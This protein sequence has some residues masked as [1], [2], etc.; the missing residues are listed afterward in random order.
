MTRY[1]PDDAIGDGATR[2]LLA[3]L[4]SPR[5]TVRGIMEATGKRSTSTVHE[6]LKS[7]RRLGLVTW[8]DHKDGTLRANC[9]RIVRRKVSYISFGRSL[10]G[11]PS[12]RFARRPMR[13]WGSIRWPN[14]LNCG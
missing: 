2:T 5:P 1:L 4:A 10:I 11:T 6:H 7:L 8:S 9:Q 14:C 13:K 3:L 12:V